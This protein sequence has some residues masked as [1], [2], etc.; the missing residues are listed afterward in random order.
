[1]LLVVW[2][3]FIGMSMV[4]LVILGANW[5]YRHCEY[6]EKDMEKTYKWSQENGASVERE[7]ARPPNKEE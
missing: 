4:G 7:K 3:V 5:I 1:M 6:V 2:Y